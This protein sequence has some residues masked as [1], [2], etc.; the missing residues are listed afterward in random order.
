MAGGS[1]R[2]KHEEELDVAD[3]TFPWVHRARLWLQ[4]SVSRQTIRTMVL[5]CT[6]CVPPL[7]ST[8]PCAHDL[9]CDDGVQSV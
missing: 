5:I 1:P 2:P 6:W 7:R 9:F 4:D 8:T 3:R